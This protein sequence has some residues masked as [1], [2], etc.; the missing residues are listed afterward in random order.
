[1]RKEIE[2]Y[3]LDAPEEQRDALRRI[4]DKIAAE[5]PD[6]EPISPN[7]FD[8]ARLRRVEGVEDALSRG[9]GSAR[10]RD[11]PRGVRDVYFV[12]LSSPN[13]CAAR[14]PL[15]F[16]VF[17]VPGPLRWREKED[18]PMHGVRRHAR[19]G[20]LPCIIVLRLS[21]SCST[22]FGRVFRGRGFV[23]SRV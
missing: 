8:R 21:R 1:M 23:T 15:G 12:S 16:R 9:A 2:A 14:M 4:H 13:A 5:M 18:P 11:D 6:V 22:G 3:I 7:G 19:T 17:E 20:G 10:G